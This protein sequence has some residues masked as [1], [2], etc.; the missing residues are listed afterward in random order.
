MRRTS[1]AVTA[2]LVLALLLVVALARYAGIP[3][4]GIAQAPGV[5]VGLAAKLACSGRYVSRFE[6]S[7]VREDIRIFSPALELVSLDFSQA[8]SVSAELLGIHATAMFYPGLGCTLQ[9]EG[10]FPL[11]SLSQPAVSPAADSLSLVPGEDGGGLQTTLEGTLAKDNANGL[12][13]RALLLARGHSV[14]AEAYAPG[15]TPETPLLGWSMG[16]SFTALVIGRMQ[17]LGLLRSQDHHLFPEW[18]GDERAEI[19]LEQMLQMV[20][21]LEFSEAYIPGND[22]TRMLFGASSASA[23]PLDKPLQVPPGTRFSYSS[24]T[25]NLLCRLISERLGGPQAFL[26]FLAREVFAPLGLRRTVMELDPSGH[27]VGSSF[28]YAPARDW[29]R[30]AQ[31]LLNAGRIGERQW[32]SA[33]WAS[34]AASPNRSRNDPR[35][36]YQLWLNRGGEAPRWPDLPPDAF[37]MSGHNGQVVM[38]IPSLDLV[39]V[40]LGWSSGQYPVNQ[41]TRTVIESL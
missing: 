1:L 33:G 21:G 37:A 23:V 18:A 35:Y 11:E 39:F 2:A 26:N 5:G 29:A 19:R 10:M 16:K 9:H 4:G 22:S 6:E 27:C 14:L 32:L 24:G 25:T 30:M 36:G 7:R 28:V 31:P 3:V 38:I 34:R 20:S 12:D 13:T 17:A 8:G 15:I 40:R 41:R